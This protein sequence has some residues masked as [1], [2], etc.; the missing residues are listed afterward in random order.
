MS[1]NSLTARPDEAP[2]LVEA[3]QSYIRDTT[4]DAL[5]RAVLRPLCAKL[6]AAWLHETPKPVRLTEAQTLAIGEAAS[7]IIHYI[8]TQRHISGS[9]HDQLCSYHALTL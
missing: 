4:Q 8:N 2:L 6:F 1:T 9:L 7:Y 5:V 3:L